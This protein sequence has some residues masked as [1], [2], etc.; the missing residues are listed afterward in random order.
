MFQ[1]SFRR[2]HSRKKT[3]P[4]SPNDNYI[5]IIAVGDIMMGST[6]PSNHLPPEDGKGIFAGVQEKLKTG[7]IVFGNLEGP[8]V[9]NGIPV[10]CKSKTPQCLNL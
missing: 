9:D 2:N 7:D 8:L 4:E 3:R 5:T 10:K 1:D 6:Y